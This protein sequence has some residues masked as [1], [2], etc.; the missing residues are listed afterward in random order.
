MEA[1]KPAAFEIELFKTTDGSGGVRKEG[2]WPEP[3]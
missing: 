3:M 1:A 2:L